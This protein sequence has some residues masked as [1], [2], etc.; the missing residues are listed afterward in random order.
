L[1]TGAILHAAGRGRIGALVLLGADPLADFPDSTAA[2]KGLLGARF[3][4]AVDSHFNESSR[5]ADVVL[6]AAAWAE[7]R[8]SVTNIEGRITWLGQL[9]TD[10]G[11]A[12]PDWMIASELSARLGVDLGYGSLE[13]IWAEVV[14]LSPLHAGVD[15]ALLTGLRARDGVVVPTGA[16]GSIRAPRPLDPMADPG[17]SS[18]ELHPVAPTAIAVGNGSRSPMPGPKEDD[19]AGDTAPPP[20][21]PLMGLPADGADLTAPGAQSQTGPSGDSVTLRLVTRRTMWDGGTQTQASPHL[22][23]LAPEPALRVSPAALAGLGTAEGETVTVRSATGRMEV[24]AV[25]DHRLPPGAALLDWNLPGVRV[26]DL[27]DGS[28]P[29]TEIVVH[30]AEGGVGD[31]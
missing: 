11:V 29:F 18:A 23:S 2:V 24:P 4:V 16:E 3:V 9:V 7:R 5:R 15:S 26:G 13:D 30:A 8:G 6:P 20:L 19:G 17:I 12:W 28:A 10:H 31:G 25:T 27:I 22:S 14:A 21:P 1:D